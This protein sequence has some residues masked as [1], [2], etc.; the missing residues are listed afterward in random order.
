MIANLTASVEQIRHYAESAL[1]GFETLDLET[2]AECAQG[3]LRGLLTYLDA[4]DNT[5]SA[6]A[7]QVMGGVKPLIVLERLIGNGESGD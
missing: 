2:A 3:N 5:D 6:V 1:N 4:L 7:V